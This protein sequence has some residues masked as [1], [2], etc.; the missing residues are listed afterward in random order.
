MPSVPLHDIDDVLAWARDQ[1]Q[2]NLNHHNAYLTPQQHEDLTATFVEHLY[3]W[4]DPRNPNAWNPNHGQTFKNFAK[5]RLQKRYI[6]WLRKEFTDDRYRP[7]VVFCELTDTDRNQ[8]RSGFDI[9]MEEVLA[10]INTTILSP[11]A[12]ATLMFIARPIIEEGQTVDEI[13][14]RHNRPHKWVSRSLQQ[15][16]D[17]LRQHCLI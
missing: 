7:R 17:E 9:P 11:Q 5:D 13:A 4:T 2:R 15:L 8:I 3:R 12:Q 14:S 10:T 6:D 1:A 16:R